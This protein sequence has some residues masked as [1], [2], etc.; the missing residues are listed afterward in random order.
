V[1]PDVEGPSSTAYI[2]YPEQLRHFERI[3][4]LRDFLIKEAEDD[5][6]AVR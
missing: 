1:L 3:A 2:V 4:V 6:R 5:P